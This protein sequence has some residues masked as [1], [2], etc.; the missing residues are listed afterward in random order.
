MR[1]QG[2]FDDA[3]LLPGERLVRRGAARLCIDGPPGWWEG[4]L[5]LTSER[6][7]FLPDAG[8]DRI[9]PVAYWLT[10]LEAGA[11]DDGRLLVRL[12]D[13]AATFDLPGAWPRM[14]RVNSWVDDIA[15]TRGGATQHPSLRDPHR[16]AG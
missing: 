11:A 9:G 12:E 10:E 8:H 3:M 13:E 16:A 15:R 1:G 2:W 5:I 6:L 14:R 4:R 7:F